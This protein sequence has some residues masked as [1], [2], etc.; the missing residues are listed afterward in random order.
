MSRR[1]QKVIITPEGQVL[2]QLRAKCDLSMIDVA[3]KLGISDSYVSQI[4]NGRANPP[5]DE[6]L[7]K[8]LALYGGV[9]KKYFQELCRQW[10]QEITDAD[11]I[12]D[13]VEKLS[14]DNQ[15]LIKAMMQTMLAKK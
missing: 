1:T 11:F 14:S 2:K 5:K 15:K 6:M 7:D 12:I 10:E 9:K 13:N 3:E 8:F 4:E